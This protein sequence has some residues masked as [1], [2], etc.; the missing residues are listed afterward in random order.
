MFMPLSL[1]VLT[2]GRE[3]TLTTLPR[4]VQRTRLVGLLA[5]RGGR[6]SRG[7]LVWDRGQI[8][9]PHFQRKNLVFVR[10]VRVS[11]DF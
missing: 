10:K 6:G 3:V 9:D 7:R 4:L 11:R 5:H 1:E 2:A 8:V